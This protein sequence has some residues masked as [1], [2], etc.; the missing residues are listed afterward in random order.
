MF[1]PSEALRVA[2]VILLA[3]LLADGALTARHDDAGGAAPAAVRLA[4][5]QV[6]AVAA[7]SIGAV[8]LQ[9]D[10][11]PAVLLAGLFV[12]MLYLAGAR[13]RSLVGALGV[14]A[15]GALGVLLVSSRAQERVVIW[16][17]PWSS[18]EG[19]G[20]QALQAIGGLASGDV[21]GAGP[22]GGVPTLIPAA[23]TDYPF[24]VI[25]EEWG[26][27]GTLACLALYTVLTV[28]GLQ[29]ASGV[30]G[31][32]AQLLVAGLAASI[33]LQV[34]VPTAGTLRLIPLTGVTSPFVSY[35]GSSTLM[36]WVVLGLIVRLAQPPGRAAP[37]GMATRDGGAA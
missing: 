26:L 23:H 6:A 17:D 15:A 11:G 8:V 9:G 14:L 7:L 1:Q 3:G 22:A 36:S 33:G 28:R 2:T 29:L 16:L 30:R 18:A 10:L 34:L 4:S 12:A 20:Y 21:L 13:Q 32:G 35:G 25:G 37:R 19:L 31:R 24:A 27:V 5:V